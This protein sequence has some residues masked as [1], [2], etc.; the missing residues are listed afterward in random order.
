MRDMV[1]EPRRTQ[2]HAQDVPSSGV[3]DTDAPRTN[4]YLLIGAW[5]FAIPTIGALLL[6]L[7]LSLFPPSFDNNGNLP[8]PISCGAPALFDRQA[9]KKRNYGS[10][11]GTSGCTAVVAARK[12]MAFGALTVA[13]PLALLAL[14]LHL[15]RRTARAR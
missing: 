1:H 2:G 12:S 15:H 9:F 7:G 14:A 5:I 6:A 10:E 13:A 4:R 8:E 11:L 3:T